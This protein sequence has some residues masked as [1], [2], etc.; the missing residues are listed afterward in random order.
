M[1]CG[2]RFTLGTGKLA[3]R[4]KACPAR[5]Q[6]PRHRIRRWHRYQK[7]VASGLAIK[8]ESVC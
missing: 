1:S 7:L 6:Q 2:G 5:P 3:P 8:L 4:I